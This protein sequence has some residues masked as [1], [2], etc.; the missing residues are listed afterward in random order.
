MRRGSLV[1]ALVTLAALA[2]AVGAGGCGDGALEAGGGGASGPAT[3]TSPG[4]AASLRVTYGSGEEVR[5]EHLR[6]RGADADVCARLA[7]LAPALRPEP[8]EVCT[9]I[10]GGPER[11]T[12]TGRL[13]GMRVDLRVTRIDGCEIQRYDLLEATLA[14]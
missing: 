6:C 12:V 5:R 8:E 9:Q 1:T 14:P 13:G 10:Y 3:A 11:I 2:L 4:D 7:E